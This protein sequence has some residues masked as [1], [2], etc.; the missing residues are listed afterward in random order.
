[1]DIV[2]VTDAWFPQVNG[3]VRT[4][5]TLRQRLSKLGRNLKIVAPSEFRTI[6]CPTYPEIRLSVFPGRSLA[7]TIRDANPS[8]IH[9]ATEGPLGIAARSFCKSQGLP[10]TTSFHTLFPEYIYARWRL[11]VACTYRLL[12]FFHSAATRTMVA[13][14]S[15]ETN[16]RE[17]GFQN[18]ARW[19]RGVDTDVFYPRTEIV[20]PYARPLFLYAGRVAVEKNLDAFL[21][22]PLP[23]SKV[24]VGDG[25]ALHELKNTYPAA[26]F[27]G[28]KTGEELAQHYSDADVFVFPSRTD[29]FGLVM[30]EALAS[31]TPVAAFPVPG[32]IDVIGESLAGCL[33]NDLAQAAMNALNMSSAECTLHA[34]KFTWEKS[35]DQFTSNL[36][37]F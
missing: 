23:G 12:R 3:V 18:L 29:T 8:A 2:V 9:I 22:L 14:P 5:D 24:V 34:E 32:P 1:M 37:F 10:F 33:N 27:V 25:P 31:G 11:P 30:V 21:S 28:V 15:I 17:R 6:A 4:F 36:A 26:I 20:L 35:I 16:L 7:R 13:T 19:T